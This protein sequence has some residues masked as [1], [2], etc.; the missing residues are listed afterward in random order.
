MISPVAIEKE[1][2]AFEKFKKG[3]SH[4]QSDQLKFEGSKGLNVSSLTKVIKKKLI[5]SIQLKWKRASSCFSFWQS[6]SVWSVLK[7]ALLIALCVLA[8]AATKVSLD[9]L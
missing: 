9:A 8:N 5:Q 3:N 2:N 4:P 1:I 7:L 6:S